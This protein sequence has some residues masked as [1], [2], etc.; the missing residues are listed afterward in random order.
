MEADTGE[1][2]HISAVS[3]GTLLTVGEVRLELDPEACTLLGAI[4]VALAK[5]MEERGG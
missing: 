3:G 1:V 4:L 5:E 2:L